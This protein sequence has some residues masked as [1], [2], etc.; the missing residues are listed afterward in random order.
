MQSAL[1]HP[2]PVQDYLHTELQA[3]RIVGLIPDHPLIQ[4]S[5]FGV[6]PKSGQPDKW[7]LILYLSSPHGNSVNDAISKDLCSITVYTKT[8]LST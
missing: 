1:R 3:Y 8:P 5:R 6:I 4:I 7:H 2:M